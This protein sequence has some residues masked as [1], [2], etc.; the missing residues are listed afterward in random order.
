M[1]NSGHWTTEQE[2]W[3]LCPGRRD[4]P[5][6]L[7]SPWTGTVENH[8][9]PLSSKAKS[10]KGSEKNPLSSGYRNLAAPFVLV[11]VWK[12]RPRIW[13]LQSWKE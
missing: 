11:Y 5:V 10:E 2:S 3:P 9:C 1:G 4:D 8:H 7:G 13:D 12:Q 6:G